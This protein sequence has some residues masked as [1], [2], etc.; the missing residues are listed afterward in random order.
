MKNNKITGKRKQRF[1]AFLTAMVM[2]VQF[3]MPLSASATTYNINITGLQGIMSITLF[4]AT[5]FPELIHF[6]RETL[7]PKQAIPLK[8]LQ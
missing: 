3:I 6:C 7:L 4:R 2:A 5:V 8:I 1:F